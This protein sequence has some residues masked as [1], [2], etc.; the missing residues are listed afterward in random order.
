ML[1]VAQQTA[2]AQGKSWSLGGISP[3]TGSNSV[4]KLS[5]NRFLCLDTGNTYEVHVAG[6]NANGQKAVFAEWRYNAVPMERSC[7]ACS[8]K[9]IAFVKALEAHGID[10]DT[11]DSMLL[12]E[13]GMT[14]L[15]MKDKG[16]LKTVKTASAQDMLDGMRKTAGFGDKFPMETC[17]E[18]IARKYGENALAMSGPCAGKPLAECACK[19]LATAGVYANDLAIKVAGIYSVEDQ[20]INCV[21]DF[22]RI[23]KFSMKQACVVCEQLKNKFAATEDMIVEAMDAGTDEP[24]PTNPE[25]DDTDS[26]K[27]IKDEVEAPVDENIDPFADETVSVE[28]P[29]DLLEKLDAVLDKALG[30]EPA[31]EE[32]HKEKAH[33][34]PAVEKSE[35]LDVAV[36]ET[37]MVPAGT[38]VVAPNTEIKQSSEEES[39][40]ES[41]ENSKDESED[42]AHEEQE[43]EDEDKDEDSEKSEDD[44]ETA[45]DEKEEDAKEE[46]DKEDDAHNKDH[47]NKDDTV[48]PEHL[49]KTGDPKVDTE[50]SSDADIFRKGRISAT[51]KI[52]LNLDAV[53]AALNGK[54]TKVADKVNIVNNHKDKDL[55]KIQDGKP[56]GHESK[57]D[58]KAPEVPEGGKKAL[59]GGEADAKLDVVTNTPEFDAGGGEMGH[60]K[61][62]GYTSEKTHDA[63]G[64]DK[65]Q[66]NH[67]ASSKA[68]TTVLAERIMN[69]MKKTASDKKVDE[70]KP[71]VET[72]DVGTV[73]KEDMYTGDVG[74][75]DD[76]QLLGHEKDTV[77]EIPKAGKDAPSIPVGGGMNPKFDKNEKNKPELQTAVKGTVIA[78]SDAETVAIRK[79]AATKIAG[80]KLKAGLIT[81]DKLASEIE[82]LARYELSDLQDIEAALFGASK[83]GLD[84]VAKGVEKPLVIS[85]RSNQRMVAQELRDSIQSLFTLNRS[86]MLAQDDP[87]VELRN[88]N[89][90]FDR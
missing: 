60:E 39:E 5:D 47:E 69:S 33:A 87:N 3:Y 73:A 89:K 10:E 83:K 37:E 64:G 79:E 20:M 58:A 53:L 15:A 54:Q 16:L 41:K 8:R 56:M 42:E 74:T 29:K 40:D 57:F 21:E 72:A 44:S 65:G 90:R 27:P 9:K 23:N 31:A 80:R 76:N 50:A 25:G 46:D 85:E 32:H 81:L 6:A 48:K 86:N 88:L 84:T 35:A 13:K 22:V 4:L 45:V 24:T 66:G 2:A 77:K 14:I 18:K 34:E 71:V 63:T 11:F 19:K 17:M 67:K 51:G 70:A 55:G 38:D 7:P 26:M 82:K 78:G 28:L 1:K 30:E 49:Q 61:E 62:L 12:P 36:K 68:R 52:N 43:I 75:T 59:M